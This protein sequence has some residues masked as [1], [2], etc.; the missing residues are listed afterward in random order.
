MI[1]AFIFR[2][3]ASKVQTDS[4]SQSLHLIAASCN[5]Q[6]GGRRNRP[7]GSRCPLVLRRGGSGSAGW[8]VFVRCSDP[9]RSYGDRGGA[10]LPVDAVGVPGRLVA[11]QHR[12]PPSELVTLERPS[13]DLGTDTEGPEP[14]EASG[15]AVVSPA[16]AA[17]DQRESLFGSRLSSS[18]Q[19][20]TE[21][22]LF[23][24]AVILRGRNTYKEPL[25][26]RGY[27][28]RS[29]Y[30]QTTPYFGSRLFSAIQPFSK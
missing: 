6:G 15:P 30:L 7:P 17:G 29:K 14:A 4:I 27:P 1:I 26:D 19:I 18:I 28:P 23:R 12:R 21:N 3:R 20:L 2:F 8:C 11:A 22:P 9:G 16:A 25:L 5:N 13:A 24:I 10:G